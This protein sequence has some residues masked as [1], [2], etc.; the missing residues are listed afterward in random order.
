V[1]RYDD[2]RNRGS[3]V[4]QQPMGR[5]KQLADAELIVQHRRRVTQKA[6]HTNHDEGFVPKRQ[7]G[8]RRRQGGDSSIRLG[9]SEQQPLSN[10]G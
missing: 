5:T 9:A 10:L 1:I 3:A 4:K 7:R 8:V 6:V 2:T